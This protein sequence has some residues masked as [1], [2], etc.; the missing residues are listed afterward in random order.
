[1]IFNEFEEIVL[2]HYEPLY[3]FAFS[4]ARTE[5]DAEDL[6]QQAFYVW[7]AKGH[8]LRD[9]SKVKTWLFTTLHRAFLE[10]RRRQT[11][12]PHHSLDEIAPDDLPTT[13][14][15][16]ADNLDSSQV[17]AALARVDE[18]YQAAVALFYLE[19]YSYRD[20]SEILEVPIGTVKSRMSRGIMQ[21]R[22]MIGPAASER[23]SD[24]FS[25]QPDGELSD[26]RCSTAPF[27][28]RRCA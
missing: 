1:M 3:R 2:Q 25:D 6:T 13:S 11:R 10:S 4:L 20:I 7:A 12:F 18:V 14:P 16:S 15:H 5:S 23:G 22:Q 26:R 28:S 19:D 24:T 21:L 27:D 9:R 17:L 8:Q